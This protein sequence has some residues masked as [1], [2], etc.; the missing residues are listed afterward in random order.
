MTLFNDKESAVLT[1]SIFNM[2]E[3][4]AMEWIKKNHNYDL[5][6]SQYCY[7]LAQIDSNVEKRR[8]KFIL[9]G[10]LAKQIEAIDRLESL[11]SLSYTNSEACIEDK[12]FRDAQFVYNSI[13]RLQEILTSYYDEVQDIIEYDTDKAKENPQQYSKE[14]QAEQNVIAFTT[15]YSGRRNRPITNN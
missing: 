10:V 11:I 9:E 4:K 13:A 6:R 5:T 7:V 3:K 8:R 14:T 12:K 1:T 15:E 2:T